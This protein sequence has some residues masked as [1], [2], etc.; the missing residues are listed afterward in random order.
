MILGENAHKSAKFGKLKKM[1]MSSKFYQIKLKK[2]N[3]MHCFILIMIYDVNL[4]GA[5]TNGLLNPKFQVL[6]YM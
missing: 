4:A 1:I 6:I 2:Q 5:G 3:K